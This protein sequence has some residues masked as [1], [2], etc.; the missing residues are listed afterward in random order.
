M[1]KYKIENNKSY[2]KEEWEEVKKILDKQIPK[3]IDAILKE[4]K[5]EI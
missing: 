3:S 5:D 2:T 1:N 4:R